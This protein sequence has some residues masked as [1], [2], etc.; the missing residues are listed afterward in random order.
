MLRL[1]VVLAGLLLASAGAAM[2]QDNQTFAEPGHGYSLAYPTNWDL[3]VPGP[4]AIVLRPPSATAGGPV[5][6]SVENARQPDEAGVQEGVALLTERYLSELGNHARQVEVHRQAPFHWDVQGAAPL[7]G[8]QIVA[9]FLRDEIPYRQWA[10]FLP[11]PA[12]P[13]VHVWLFTAPQNLFA[14]WRPT[15]ETILNSLQP[16]RK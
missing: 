7:I 1:F 16:A 14:E 4:F 5:A 6:V 13:V 11:N 2:A 3:T 10:V 12:G 8:R 9:D 15:A